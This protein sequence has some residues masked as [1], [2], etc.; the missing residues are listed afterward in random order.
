MKRFCLILLLFILSVSGTIV[1]ADSN[2]TPTAKP[3][4][5]PTPEP[6]IIAIPTTDPTLAPTPEPTITVT[7]TTDST[8]TPTP[9]PTITTI[10]TTDPTLAP[11]P[12]PTI[13]ATPTVTVSPTGSDGY[14]A[15]ANS[16]PSG[17]SESIETLAGSFSSESKDIDTSDSGALP[18]VLTLGE[19][20]ITA[21]GTKLSSAGGTG[22]TYSSDDGGYYIITDSG[23]YY[24]DEDL[25][26]SHSFA[27]EIQASSVTLDGNGKTLSG[28][29]SNIGIN[30]T[31]GSNGVK[32]QNFGSI[33]NFD[34]G[35]DSWSADTTIRNNVITDNWARGIYVAGDNAVVDGNTANDNV[36][37]GIQSSGMNARITNNTAERNTQAIESHG[38]GANLSGNTLTD[39]SYGLYAGADD[40]TISNNTIRSSAYGSLRGIDSGGDNATISGNSAEGYYYGIESSGDYASL[41]ENNIHNNSYYGIYSTGLGV[42]ISDNDVSSNDGYADIYS[43]GDDA[44]IT[45]NNADSGLKQ[46]DYG[47]QSIGKNALIEHNL[48]SKHENSGIVA[49]GQNVTIVQNTASYNGYDGIRTTGDNAII[50]GNV[51][52][53]NEDHGTNVQSGRNTKVSDNTASDNLYGIYVNDNGGQIS[54]NTVFNNTFGICNQGSDAVI[55]DNTVYKNSLG[56]QNLNNEIES[57]NLTIQNNKVSQNIYGVAVIDSI[58]SVRVTGNTIWNND[59][60]IYIS[61]DGGGGN[62]LI[63]DNYLGNTKNVDGDGNPGVYDWSQTPSPGKNIVGGPNVAGNFW[64][65]KTGTGWSDN[66][67]GNSTGYSTTPYELSTGVYDNAPLV[68]TPSP[69]PTSKPSPVPINDPSNPSEPSSS[70][71]DTSLDDPLPD[72]PLYSL[73]VVSV[74]LSEDATPGSSANL[75]IT[76]ENNGQISPPAKSIIRLIPENDLA[77]EVGEL[78]G[79]LED[80]LYVFMCSLIIPTTPGSYQY[81]F[82]PVLVTTDPTT[83]KKV[84]VPFGDLVNFTVI[85]SEDGTVSVTIS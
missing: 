24:L 81:T 53:N 2:T 65:N 63:V 49:T 18:E 60:G 13:T 48:A 40:A 1:L 3:T 64:S 26:T 75:F 46:T 27:I 39:N 14:D 21:T 15:G 72:S 22:Y 73:K 11:T 45:S 76:L 74:T 20:V 61:N 7:P 31:S 6:T 30:I 55:S 25:S 58:Q 8:L 50:E 77:N 79:D 84:R 80:G 43:G 38:R 37:N 68:R 28:S 29:F 33:T 34:S 66:Q 41:S 10:P 78:P 5:V 19:I 4:S 57:E 59:V 36:I 83:G 51:I 32:I 82:Q 12:E 62:G 71:R 17:S 54:G 70:L 16:T 42:T 35:I 23:D 52:S 69:T 67:P 9:E 56:I 85:V 47:I 44:V